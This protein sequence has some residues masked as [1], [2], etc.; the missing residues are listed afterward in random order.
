MLV[1]RRHLKISDNSVPSVPDHLLADL[2]ETI[3][4]RDLEEKIITLIITRLGVEFGKN[5]SQLNI[6][7]S[8]LITVAKLRE[9]LGVSVSEIP[10]EI[11]DLYV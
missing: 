7:V 10:P 5:S 9:I 11:M 6:T 8:N 3:E 1:Y 2:R 4:T